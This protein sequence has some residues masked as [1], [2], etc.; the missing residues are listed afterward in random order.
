M[1]HTENGDMQFTVRAPVLVQLFI[2]IVSLLIRTAW[3]FMDSPQFFPIIPALL[4]LACETVN[5]RVAKI[6]FMK[7]GI[8]V[9]PE[10]VEVSLECLNAE[11]TRTLPLRTSA[12]MMKNRVEGFDRVL[13]LRLGAGGR[14]TAPVLADVLVQA[15]IAEF[16][17]IQDRCTHTRTRGLRLLPAWRWHIVSETPTLLQSPVNSQD[18]EPPAAWLAKCPVC[19]TGILQKVTGKQL[20]GLPSMDYY[21]GCTHCGAKFVPEKENFRLVSIAKIRDP[22]WRHLLNTSRSADNWVFLAQGDMIFKQVP[23]PSRHLSS[24]PVGDVSTG[25]FA[26]MKDGSIAVPFGEKTLFFQPVNLRFGRIIQEALFSKRNRTLADLV[27][28]RE[29]SN[30]KQR[31]EQ[32]YYR[33][34]PVMAGSFLAEL[35]QLDDPLVREF[36]HSY[37]DEEYCSFRMADDEHTGQKG[38]IVM[39]VEGK[40]KYIGKCHSSFGTLINDELG[41]IIPDMC[42]RD[43]NE[44]ACKVNSLICAD[45]DS[46]ALFIHAMTDDRAI[47]GL[48]SDLTNRY[49]PVPLP[50]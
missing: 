2:F 20:F 10:L 9:T 44:T 17:E 16:A 42:Y 35:K 33:Y 6:P 45:R 13:E 4:T 50:G 25:S 48:V 31:I 34:L 23:V 29:Y 47:E 3:F 43:G 11:V 12:A 8:I 26:K 46:F 14:A 28:L 41:R 39:L 1:I 5:R 21:I 7:N 18:A 32:Q 49:M 40:V 36:L 22:R 38:V 19:K 30:L 27:T 37:G 24:K 15:W